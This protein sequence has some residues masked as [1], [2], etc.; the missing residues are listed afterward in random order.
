MAVNRFFIPIVRIQSE[1]GH[2]LVSSGPYRFV[3]HPGYAGRALVMVCSGPALGSWI[4]VIPMLIFV[5]GL[6]HRVTVEDR[7]LAEN[8]EGYR[9]YAQ[10]VRFRLLPSVF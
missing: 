4:A 6:F 7:F 1:R 8:L 5:T 10:R 2:R 3:R 9:E